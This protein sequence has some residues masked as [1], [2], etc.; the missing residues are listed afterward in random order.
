MP[1]LLHTRIQQ[2][3]LLSILASHDVGSPSHPSPSF[4]QHQDSIALLTLYFDQPIAL[5]QVPSNSSALP[6][7]E[8]IIAGVRCGGMDEAVDVQYW[9]AATSNADPSLRWNTSTSTTAGSGARILP[10]ITPAST[11]ATYFDAEQSLDDDDENGENDDSDSG[12][13]FTRASLSSDA[14]PFPSNALALL[15]LLES[16][17]AVGIDAGLLNADELSRCT[18]SLRLHLLQPSTNAQRSS[19]QVLDVSLTPRKQQQTDASGR[20]IPPKKRTPGCSWSA[21]LHTQRWILPASDQPPRHQI[22]DDD[23]ASSFTSSSSAPNASHSTFTSACASLRAEERLVFLESGVTSVGALLG[24]VVSTM[25][26]PVTDQIQDMA[27][28]HTAQELAKNYVSS[29][30]ATAPPEVAQFVSQKLSTAV[31][32]Q[33]VDM[34]TASLTESVSSSISLTLGDYLSNIV[35]RGI[36]PIIRDHVIGALT[37]IIPPDLSTRLATSVTK[38]LPKHII[39]DVSQSLTHT[40]VGSL[41]RGLSSFNHMQKLCRTCALYNERC[42]DCDYVRKVAHESNF[43]AA[44]YSQYYGKYYADYYAPIADQLP[45]DSLT[46]TIIQESAGDQSI[47]QTFDIE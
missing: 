15:V 36:G 3:H 14:A 19:K 10:L 9:T 28:V 16:E 4:Q 17:D 2:L 46:P 1:H 8:R 37:Q 6:E 35:P 33:V 32:D 38:T 12:L 26:S 34:L 24:G 45:I 5:N 31:T 7:D 30:I 20:F 29:V 39:S 44:Y 21:P 11:W 41:S 43:Y 40:L 22:K 42:S 25:M 27:P 13:F 18:L 47:W 23:T